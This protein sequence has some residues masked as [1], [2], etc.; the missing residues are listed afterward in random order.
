MGV[1]QQCLYEPSS[2]DL[3]PE[4][5]QSELLERFSESR[6]VAVH[7]HLVIKTDEKV[8]DKLYRN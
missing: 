4:A 3:C 8:N 1:L 7:Q 6:L 5:H 2:P